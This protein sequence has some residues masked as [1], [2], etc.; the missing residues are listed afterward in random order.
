M[1][2]SKKKKYIYIKCSKGMAKEWEKWV[3]ILCVKIV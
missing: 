2:K 3:A 1:F